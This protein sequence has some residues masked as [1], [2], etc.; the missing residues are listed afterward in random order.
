M[1]WTTRSGGGRAADEASRV[2]AV[3]DR[4][5]VETMT[6]GRHTRAAGP[7]ESPACRRALY[8]RR[9]TAVVHVWWLARNALLAATPGHWR[10]ASAIRAG[11]A[12]DPVPADGQGGRSTEELLAAVGVRSDPVPCT[13][14]PTRSRLAGEAGRPRTRARRRGSSGGCTRLAD[15]VDRGRIDPSEFDP[16]PRLAARWRALCRLP[17]RC[18]ARPSLVW[19]RSCRSV[20]LRQ[21][22]CFGGAQDSTDRLMLWPS[23]STWPG[24][25]KW[26]AARS[27]R[28]RAR[29]VVVLDRRGRHGVRRARGGGT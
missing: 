16:P 14:T 6:P 3:R 7:R 23:C 11:R 28:L 9:P 8:A 26:S 27:S 24:R 2:V 15:A 10:L 12:V 25:P 22:A 4:D 13:G 20:S 18:A 17:A 19:R 1:T 5:L 29:A 21:R